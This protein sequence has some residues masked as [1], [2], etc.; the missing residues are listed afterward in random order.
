LP[1]KSEETKKSEDKEAISPIAETTSQTKHT[2]VSD[3]GS[4]N[5]TV[6]TGTLILKEEDI[7]EGEKQ[8]AS[9]FYIAYIKDDDSPDRPVTFSFN[10]GPGSS[11]VWMH[12]G[13]LGPKRVLVDDDGMPLA[14]H[15]GWLIMNSL[16]LIS[17]IWFLL[18]RSAPATAGQSLKKNRIN[19]T[20]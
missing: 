7:E 19:F 14:H 5:Y 3:D 16:C 6:T 9:I 2:F 1:E 11:S 12:L 17:R 20:L 8:K 15:I 4:F 18:T 10:G 13:L